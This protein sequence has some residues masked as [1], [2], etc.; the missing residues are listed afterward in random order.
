MPVRRRSRLEDKGA[1]RAGRPVFGD[2]GGEI[3]VKQHVSGQHQGR[4]AL[5]QEISLSRNAP[6][7]AQG[8]SLAGIADGEVL[9]G[10]ARHRVL[11]AAGQMVEID[12]GFLHSVVG[13]QFQQPGDDRPAKDGEGGLGAQER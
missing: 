3:T 8:M 12:C 13:E 10:G 5:R 1:V 6:S 4:V 7:G 9:G 2:Q 11:D